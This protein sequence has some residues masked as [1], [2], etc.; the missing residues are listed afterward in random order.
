MLIVSITKRLAFVR[1]RRHG[2]LLF[3]VEGD[4]ASTY[5]TGNY[6]R[7]KGPHR[8]RLLNVINVGNDCLAVTVRSAGRLATFISR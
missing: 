5:L 4:D 6:V 2:H 7:Y 1:H 8:L 3:N